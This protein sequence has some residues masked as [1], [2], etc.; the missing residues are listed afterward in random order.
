[1]MALSGLMAGYRPSRPIPAMVTLG[2]T[3]FH[4]SPSR[5]TINRFCKENTRCSASDE[6][7]FPLRSFPPRRVDQ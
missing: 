1:M 5:C 2:V 3:S 7:R 4:F 6:S